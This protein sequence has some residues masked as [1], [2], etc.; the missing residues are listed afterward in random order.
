MVK[1]SIIRTKIRASDEAEYKAFLKERGFDNV[2]LFPSKKHSNLNIYFE[3]PAEMMTYTLR[4]L[5]QSFM[6]SRSHVYYYDL[7]DPFDELGDIFGDED[8]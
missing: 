4:G 3:K 2:E 8:N 5:E 6:A 1:A 7:E